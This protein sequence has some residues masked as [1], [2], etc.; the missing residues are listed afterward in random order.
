M[1]LI[2]S[3]GRLDVLP[4][5]DVGFKRSFAIQYGIGK[6]E[7]LESKIIIAAQNWGRYKSI[8]VWY[9]WKVIDDN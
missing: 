3:L 4:L 5:G 9:L 6:E 7:D 1:F 2:P 8:V